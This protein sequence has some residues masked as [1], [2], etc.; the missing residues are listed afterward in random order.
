[1]H[2]LQEAALLACIFAPSSLVGVVIWW[3]VPQLWWA[4]AGM[5]TTAFGIVLYLPVRSALRLEG[6]GLEFFVIGGFLGIVH[7]GSLFASTALVLEM[8]IARWESEQK[9][10]GKNEK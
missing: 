1:M 5:L 3:R 2:G 8:A 4:A 10:Q 7:L 9:V 6:D